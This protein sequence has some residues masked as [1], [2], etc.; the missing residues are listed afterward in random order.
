MEL[1]DPSLKWR[2]VSLYVKVRYIYAMI[3]GV[4]AESALH[5]VVDEMSCVALQLL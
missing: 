1:G 5:V 4:L 3:E 2:R